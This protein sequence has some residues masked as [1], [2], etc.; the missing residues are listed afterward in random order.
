MLGLTLAIWMASGGAAG[1]LP[2]R[3]LPSLAAVAVVADLKKAPKAPIDPELV[4]SDVAAPSVRDLEGREPFK[5]RKP[6]D[7]AESNRVEA[8]KLFVVATAQLGQKEVFPA[9]RTLLKAIELDPKSYSIL[10]QLSM[11]CAQL[12]RSAEAAG[13][14]K[15][16][17]EIV[18]DDYELLFAYGQF[19][20]DQNQLPAAVTVIERAAKAVKDQKKDATLLLAVRELLAELYERQ[21]DPAGVARALEDLLDIVENPAKHD[22][23]ELSARQLERNRGRYYEKLGKAYK[24]SKRLDK[25]VAIL[26]RGRD[27]GGRNQRLAFLLAE[28]YVENGD[29]AK[30]LEE[31]QSYLKSAQPQDSHVLALY[32]TI[33]TK[34]K[35]QEELLPSLEKLVDSDVHNPV[36]RLFYAQK[37]LEKKDFKKAK[38]QLEK[39]KDRPEALPVLAQ[40]L[41]QMND[42]SGFVDSLRPESF[43]PPHDEQGLQNVINLLKSDKPFLASV[44]EAARKKLGPD[45]KPTNRLFASLVIARAAAAAKEVDLAK[46][47]YQRC[48]TD[49]PDRVEFDLELLQFLFSNERYADVV[50]YCEEAIKKKPDE[51]DLHDYLAR[52]LEMQGKTDAAV[53][54]MKKLIDRIGDREV[55]VSA[56]LGLTWIY[57]HS[58]RWEPALETCQKVINDFPGARQGPTARYM[59]ASIYTLKGD[60]GGAEKE[61]LKLIDAD[62]DTVPPRIAA[63]ANNDLGYLWADS[64]KNL[65]RAETMIRRAVALQPENAAYLD[66][67]GWVLFKKKRYAESVEYLKKATA[68]EE[69]GDPVI[70]DHLGDALLQL[71]QRTEARK[72]WESAVAAYKKDP[73]E[74]N[75]D[76]QKQIE[77]KIRL[78]DKR[79]DDPPKRAAAGEP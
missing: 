61:L 54:A 20:A 16:A 47:F 67:L 37:L 38:E 23:D 52:S 13:Y 59:L 58:R 19:L 72:A 24:E 4:R 41:R 62:P 70:H 45:A 35:R 33:L 14:A 40:L 55:L 36:L 71:D 77:E 74:K 76:K 75:G 42:P 34:L 79:A 9:Y 12:D 30:A 6:L 44:A 57:Q 49:R 68:L 11:A 31:I 32:E 50:S 2:A 64:N 22:I 65:D 10:R 63:A 69:G 53:A 66:S 18:P 3:S 7:Q 27:L 29:Y 51:Y 60:N 56:Y 26:K 78:L 15:R 46:E 39:I 73:R 48:A 21:K 43:R 28:V 25:A 1:A 8:K 17:L 5:P